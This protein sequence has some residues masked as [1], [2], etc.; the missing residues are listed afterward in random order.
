MFAEGKSSTPSVCH[1]S[2]ET[3]GDG[4]V[5][6]GR[7]QC[8]R[9]LPPIAPSSSLAPACARSICPEAPRPGVLPVEQLSSVVDGAL[10]KTGCGAPTRGSS[11]SKSR[12]KRL[13]RRGQCSR[14]RSSCPVAVTSASDATV[15]VGPVVPRG[16]VC[17]RSSARSNRSRQYCDVAPPAAVEFTQCAASTVAGER[18]GK[19]SRKSAA[20][21]PPVSARCPAAVPQFAGVGDVAACQVA[22]AQLRNTKLHR[23]A[24]ASE[25]SWHLP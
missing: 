22:F 24:A 13:C 12:R 18:P 20:P 25:A 2:H 8:R 9:T 15:Q 7:K 23:S 5:R 19:P 17:R 11:L 16:E 4:C 21:P 3:T 14:A 6:A 1:A 10:S